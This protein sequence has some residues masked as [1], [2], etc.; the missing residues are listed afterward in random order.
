M[1]KT[2]Y[3][4]VFAGFFLVLWLSKYFAAGDKV[5]S[6]IQTMESS[7]FSEV[8]LIRNP[9]VED[10][11]L[12]LVFPSGEASN[13]FDEGLAHYVEHLAWLSTFGG[14]QNERMRHSNA[15]T[16]HFSTGYWQK[17]VDDDLHRALR[18]LMAVSEPFDVKV[19][20]ALEERDIVL[21]EYDYRVAE[22][23]L[24]QVYRD[25][26]RALYGEGAL[27]RSV[28][29]EPEVIADYSLDAAASLHKQSH[30]LS[31]AT[32]LVYG[33]VSEARLEAAL[34]ALSVNNVHTLSADP[35]SIRLVE[36]GVVQDRI[37]ISLS[38]LSD[39]TFLYRKLVPLD[40][41]ET[42][43]G[44]AVLAQLAENALGSSLPGGLAGPLRYDQFVTRSF[45]LD[46]TVIGEKYVELSFIGHPD[47]NISLDGLENVFRAA[48]H[49]T[50]EN[51][52]PQE[53]FDRVASRLAGQF[54]SVLERD[55]PGYNRDL[56]LD[57]LMSAT[58]VFTLE[59]QI[60]AVASVRL[61]DVNEFLK[62][63]LVDGREVTRL[64]SVE[65]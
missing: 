23:P 6:E 14:G 44:C 39:D 29:G 51:G 11:F 15:W 38:E 4:L 17:T 7:I 61:K 59:D 24:I 30:A 13:N 31:D 60:N 49:G 28:I 45:S 50:L 9:G 20:F 3:I 48:L 53:T 43:A 26:D 37:A 56:V 57:Q 54:D 65:R 8:A 12:Y 5:G 35:R 2:L 22:R 63:L 64:V 36:D 27:A 18:T 1:K 55:R 46:I 41:C 10:V 25:M 33:G 52:L 58:P 40:V 62:S 47:A 16:N 42:S 32:L 34:A 19:D 21:R